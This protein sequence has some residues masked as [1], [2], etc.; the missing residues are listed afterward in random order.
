MKRTI[1]RIAVANPVLFVIFLSAP[2]VLLAI[3]QILPTFDD[4]T[5]LSSP[6]YDKEYLKY[7]LPFG[8]VWRP[9]DALLGYINAINYKGFPILNHILIYMAHL[10]STFIVYRITKVAGFNKLSTNLSTLFFY[11]SPCVCGTIYSCDA[12]NQT[13]SHLWGIAAVYSYLIYNNKKRYILWTIFI[14]LAALSKDNGIAWSIVPPI[15][16]IGLGKE[17]SKNLIKSIAFG[18]G[19]AIVYAIITNNHHRKWFS[20]RANDE[21]GQ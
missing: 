13:Y 7:F 16:A 14:F 6:N 1:K 15:V 4:W 12:L 8:T 3:A 9:G 17:N 19:I 21:P 5:T 2:I 11:L 20:Y 10:A 18:C